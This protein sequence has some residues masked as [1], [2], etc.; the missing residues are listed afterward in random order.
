M[1]PFFTAHAT[2]RPTRFVAELIGCPWCLGLWSS[3]FLVL[4]VW[5]VTPLPLPALWPAAVAGGQMIVNGVD[6]KLDTH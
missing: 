1:R 2:N 5:A 6:L 3:T 4:A